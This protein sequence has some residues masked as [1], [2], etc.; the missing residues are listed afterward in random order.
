[1]SS[2]L[3]ALNSQLEEATKFKE[4]S[5]EIEIPKEV[6]IEAHQ[7]IENPHPELKILGDY[8]NQNFINTQ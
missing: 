4:E 2:K 3:K 8:V 6:K 1:M 5:E 7:Q